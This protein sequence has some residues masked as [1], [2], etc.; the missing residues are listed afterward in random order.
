MIPT[1]LSMSF[2]LHSSGLLPGVHRMPLNRGNVPG[3]MISVAA[4]AALSEDVF[5]APGVS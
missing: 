4:C 5:V 2:S 3:F 1:G